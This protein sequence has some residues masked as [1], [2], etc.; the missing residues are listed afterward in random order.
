MNIE[1]KKSKKKNMRALSGAIVALILVIAGVIIAIAVVLFAFGLIPG[2]S[3]Q[4][5]IQVLG[6]GTITNSTASGSSRTIYNI[7]ITVKNTGTTSISVTSINING[8]PF[9]I[10]GTAPS[11]PAGRTQPITFEV[12]PASGKPN[13]SPGASYTAT[14]YF[15]NGQGAPATLIYQG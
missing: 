13:F 14:I 15:S 8:Q 3:N 12:T 7:T 4:G 9:N 11:I 2:I 1:V 6:S 10:N 5:S